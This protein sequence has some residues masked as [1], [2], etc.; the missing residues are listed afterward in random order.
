MPKDNLQDPATP[1]YD[2]F[3]QRIDY[4]Y[5]V[6]LDVA[7][8][9]EELTAAVDSVLLEVLEAFPNVKLVRAEWV[10]DKDS[11]I[12]EY[13]GPGAGGWFVL[14]PRVDGLI[15]LLTAKLEVL[16]QQHPEAF[17]YELATSPMNGSI[18]DDLERYPLDEDAD[19]ILD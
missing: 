11:S 15:N 17:V 10:R 2:E 5:G 8:N 6:D 12:P 3:G 9:T 13:Q 4:Y 7:C 1:E 19:E 14:F 18:S 16:A